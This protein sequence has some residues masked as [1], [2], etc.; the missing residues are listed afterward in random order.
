MLEYIR[1]W[2]QI[3]FD[4]PFKLYPITI[5]FI[6]WV[7]IQWTKVIIDL[8]SYRKFML[9]NLFIAWGF[10]SFHSWISSSVTMLALLE[11]GFD[12]SVFAIAF[13]FSLLF[14]YDAMNLRY[15]AGQHAH[16][17]NKIRS[18]IGGVLLEPKGTSFVQREKLSERIGHTVWEVLWWIVFWTI[19]TFLLY[20][21]F[22]I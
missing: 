6:V 11:Y 22:I 14:S 15:Q 20:Y 12:S 16:Y 3:F 9:A 18:T 19:F 17:I 1:N 21:Y 2:F 7:I 4:A 13:V 10:P 5:V 8:F